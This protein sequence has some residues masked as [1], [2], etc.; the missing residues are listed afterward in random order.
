MNGS[1]VADGLGRWGGR[2]FLLLLAL[3]VGAWVLTCAG[4]WWLRGFFIPSGG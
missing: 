3:C 4:G 2:L 1:E